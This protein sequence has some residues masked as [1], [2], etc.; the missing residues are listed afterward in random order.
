MNYLE[1]VANV[2]ILKNIKNIAVEIP[3]K[4]CQFEEY[5]T[6]W[7]LIDFITMW[8]QNKT[9][10]NK[11]PNT[12]FL[13]VPNSAISNRCVAIVCQSELCCAWATLVHV[14]AAQKNCP[15][16]PKMSE[17][18]VIDR[19]NL[20][21]NFRIVWALTSSEFRVLKKINKSPFYFSMRLRPVHFAIIAAIISSPNLKWSTRHCALRYG[22]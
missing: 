4:T 11:F 19:Q 12:I 17:F 18:F 1:T 6:D 7:K 14:H 8:V 10:W 9:K 21:D 16:L 3:N 15:E 5:A 13:L 20:P 2:V 22:Y